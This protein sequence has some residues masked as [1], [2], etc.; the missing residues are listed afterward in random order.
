MTATRH[1]GGS[2]APGDLTRGPV[3]QAREAPGRGS[4]RPI[5]ETAAWEDL[6]SAALVGTDRRPVPG[7]SLPDGPGEAPVAPPVDLLEQ[8]AVQ[9]IRARAGQ[10]PHRGRSLPPASPEPRPLVGRAAADRLDRILAGEQGRLLPEWLEIAAAGGARVPARLVPRLLDLGARDQSIRAHLGVLTGARGRWLARLNPAWS[11]LRDEPTGGAAGSDGV[12]EFGTSGDR[13]DHLAA[14]RASDP[15]AARELLAAGWDRETPEDRAAFTRILAEGLTMADEP[16]LEAALDDRRR[17]VRQAAADLLTR[18][19]ES[20]LGTR[21]AERAARLL[22]RD[23]DRLRAEPPKAC[24]SRMERDG[25]RARPPAGTGQRGWWLQQ[26]VAHTPLSFWTGHLGLTPEEIT[27]M[28]VGDWA[29][30]VRMG[31]T[32][33]AI[34]QRDGI[35]ARALV[36]VEPLTDLLAILPPAEQSQKAADFVRRH[37]VDGQMIMMLGGIPRPWGVPLAKAVL[38][39]IASVATA[40]PWNAGELARLAGER[41]DASAYDQVARLGL[42]E[43][44]EVSATLRF[45]HDMARELSA[46]GTAAP[47]PDGSAGPS[48]SGF[49]GLSPGGPGV[50]SPDG[51]AGRGDG[52]AGGRGETSGETPEKRR[53]DDGHGAAPDGTGGPLGE[54]DK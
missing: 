54:E 27:T 42:P 46:D 50:L 28:E 26:V 30:E 37:P 40:Q 29:R 15:E 38:E 9:V 6:V 22:T 25:V 43:V 10:R 11:Y 31:W 21:M 52:P 41:F 23:G 36:E 1:D 4:G 53:T 17:E 39:K 47:S 2:A 3:D 48:P 16:F 24:D 44:H 20:R 13:R 18:L 14:L 51:P 7:G 49:A 12:W 5:P 34:L 19:P 35:W 33:A 45:R 8:A 32:R